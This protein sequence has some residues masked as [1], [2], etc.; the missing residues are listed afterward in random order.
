MKKILLL[1]LILFLGTAVF[2]QDFPYG[3]QDNAALDMKKYDKDTSA[4]AV[5][6]KEYGTSRINLTSDYHER[7]TFE[8][9]SQ[10]KFFD[11]KEFESEGTFVIPINNGDGMVY[12]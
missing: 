11:S 6:L 2:A 3:E 4:H 12:E 10:I 1:S 9:H 5:V 8:Y 7:L